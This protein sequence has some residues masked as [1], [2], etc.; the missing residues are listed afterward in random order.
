MPHHQRLASSGL[1]FIATVLCMCV[2]MQ[3][4]GVPVTLLHAA[5]VSDTIAASVLEGFSVPPMLPQL[6]MSSETNPI[7]EID[8]LEYVT[9]FASM[10]FHPPVR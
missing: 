9:A 10:P 6:V 4:L 8:L 7:A 1:C 3:M 2:M 5:D